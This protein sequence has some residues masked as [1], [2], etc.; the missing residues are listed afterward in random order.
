MAKDLGQRME[1]ET[2]NKGYSIEEFCTTLIE[3]VQQFARAGD[4]FS[5]FQSGGGAT[6]QPPVDQGARQAAQASEQGARQTAARGRRQL[7]QRQRRRT[8]TAAAVSAK[9][10]ATGRSTVGISTCRPSS[11]IKVADLVTDKAA[12]KVPDKV[13]DQVCCTLQTSPNRGPGS[14]SIMPRRR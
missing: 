9:R 12:D 8:S 1:L 7:R 4:P 3:L 13:P 14:P 10:K 6:A 5:N 11:V 2:K